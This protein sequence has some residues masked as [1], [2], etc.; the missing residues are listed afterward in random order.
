MKANKV[1]IW[2]VGLFGFVS[3]A[4]SGTIYI[5]GLIKQGAGTLTTTLGYIAN[6]GLLICTFIA[7]M[8]WISSLKVGKTFRLV[9]RIIL[10]VFGVLAFL[11]VIGLGL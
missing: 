2:L 8:M 7:A 3:F 5:L 1:L 10:I 4:V 11:G 6:I 9:L